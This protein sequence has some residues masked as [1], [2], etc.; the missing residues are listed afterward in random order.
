MAGLFFVSKFS[1][2][3]KSLIDGN[4]QFIRFNDFQDERLSGMV[5]HTRVRFVD[6]PSAAGGNGG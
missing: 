6:L 4:E 1:K 3:T 5:G 2:P